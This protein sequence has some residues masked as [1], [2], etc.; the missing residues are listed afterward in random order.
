MKYKEK[1]EQFSKTELINYIIY[2]TKCISKVQSED[3]DI[4]DIGDIDDIYIKW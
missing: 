4:E 3:Y 2:L 1:L